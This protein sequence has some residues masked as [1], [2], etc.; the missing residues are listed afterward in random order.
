MGVCTTVLVKS[1][2]AHGMRAETGVSSLLTQTIVS[3]YDNKEETITCVPITEK[4]KQQT[5]N[6][7]K[8]KQTNNQKPKHN[9]KTKPN[10]QRNKQKKNPK[11]IVQWILGT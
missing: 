3:L 10:K 11:S 5:N 7:N 8:S 6:N 4:I 9:E 1:V 2:S